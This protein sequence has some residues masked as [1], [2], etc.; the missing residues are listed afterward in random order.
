VPAYIT[1]IEL[2]CFH[3]ALLSV[4]FLSRLG[5]GTQDKVLDLKDR[6]AMPCWAARR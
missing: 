2:A 1:R 6:V 3:T 4:A 5:F